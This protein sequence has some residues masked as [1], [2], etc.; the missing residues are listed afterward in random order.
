MHPSL[1]EL[2]YAT[3]KSLRTL[4]KIRAEPE[5]FR[6]DEVPAYLPTGLGEHLFVHF[7]KRTLTTRDAVER[8]ARALGVNPRDAGFAGLKDKHAVTTQWASFAGASAELAQ[9]LDLPGIRVLAAARHENKLRTGHLRGNRFQLRIR[10]EQLDASVARTILGELERI[11]APNYY[12]EQRFGIEDRNLTRARAWVLEGG[13]APRDRFERKLLFSTL[14]SALFN[15][16]LADRLNAGLYG[17]VVPGDL[18]RK[19]DTGGMFVASDVVDAT[20]RMLAWEVSPTGPMFGGK[21]RWPEGESAQREHAVL[22]EAGIA[23]DTLSAHAKYGEGARR[24]ARVKPAGWQVDEEADA[25][26]ISFELPAGAYATMVLRELMKQGLD[27]A[28]T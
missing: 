6:V 4:G 5:D 12:G 27:G 13:R 1:R 20:T 16:W 21:M 25:L 18:M 17:S 23:L 22:R 8:L 26:L 24:P 9:S 7:E 3:A 19:E 11:G 14:Q 15:V 28:E 2:P 10:G